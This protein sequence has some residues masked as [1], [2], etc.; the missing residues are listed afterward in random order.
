MK[1][2]KNKLWFAA[3]LVGV[4][5]LVLLM[6]LLTPMVCDDYRYAFSFADGERITSVW[7]I[8]PSL[9]AHGQS[10]NGRYVPHFFVKLF[11][12]MPLV[13]F[14]VVNSLVFVLLALGIYRI[15]GWKWDED[16]VLFAG[17]CGALFVLPPAFGQNML[18]M[19]GACNYLWPAVLLCWLL[20]PFAYMMMA[21]HTMMK[22][23]YQVLMVVGGLLFGNCSENL[24][25]A[26]IMVMG[27]CLLYRLWERKHTP[28]WAWLTTVAAGVG[29][30]LLLLAPAEKNTGFVDG[31]MMGQLLERFTLVVENWIT[32][33]GVLTAVYVVFYCVIRQLHNPET[34]TLSLILAVSALCCQL[35]MVAASYFPERVLLGPVVLMLLAIGV[36]LPGI[37]EFTKPLRDGLCI[38]LCVFALLNVAAALPDIYNRHQ[39]AGARDQLMVEAA[40]AGETDVSTFGILGRTRYDAYTGL[41]ELTTLPDE[42]S[43]VA[44]AKYFGLSSVV[45]DR[46]E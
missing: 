29:W 9:A 6:N 2:N 18:W 41:V 43:N 17:I 36:L 26:G 22:K 25:A 16:P 31:G 4:F 1:E 19:S 44:Y 38:C 28:L 34:R 13:C 35:A 32:H 15:I 12:M 46:V 20:K 21:G 45:V 42:F 10:L 24:S 40:Q 5:A 14:D 11:A 27:L 7:E 30:L 33:L 23:P 8:F 39:L 3:V 37:P